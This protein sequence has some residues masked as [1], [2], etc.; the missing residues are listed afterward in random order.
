MSSRSVELSE[1]SSS[2]PGSIKPNYNKES[3]P[4]CDEAPI[5]PVVTHPKTPT[6]NRSSQSLYLLDI[7]KSV[8]KNEIH[9]CYLRREKRGPLG[10]YI[11][12]LYGEESD[13]IF[14][15]KTKSSICHTKYVIY[16]P[17]SGS[18]IGSIISD[19]RSLVYDVTGPNNL[20]FVIEYN[21]NFLGRNGCRTFS[22]IMNNTPN[23][24]FISKP[25]IVISGNYYQDFHDMETVQS[26]KNFMCVDKDDFTKEVCAFTRTH[27]N[28]CFMLRIRE[29]FTMFIGFALA[30]TSLHTG[31][32]HR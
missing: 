16:E 5:T 9:E 6:V 7:S 27:V 3:S 4:S 12:Q 8:P 11:Y 29:P 1:S 17:I 20:N 25:P 19:R 32:F 10:S 30:L 22:V 31:I 24:K 2:S 14:T 21:E 18:M 26:V 23:K 15:A 13:P 28:H